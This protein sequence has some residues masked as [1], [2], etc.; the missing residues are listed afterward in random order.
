MVSAFSFLIKKCRRNSDHIKAF[1]NYIYIVTRKRL[2][3][4]TKVKLGE[5]QAIDYSWGEIDFVTSPLNEMRL[6]ECPECERSVSGAYDVDIDVT[7]A[8]T[9][10]WEI[11]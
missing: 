2:T 5:I 6:I 3:T 4:A 9:V 1:L 11:S 7:D 8:V 10:I